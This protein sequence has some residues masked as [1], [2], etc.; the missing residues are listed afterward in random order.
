[1]DRNLGGGETNLLIG[2][3]TASYREVSPAY[4]KLHL[5]FSSKI[6]LFLKGGWESGLSYFLALNDFLNLGFHN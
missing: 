6:S 4:V 3:K 5:V 1:M 2:R